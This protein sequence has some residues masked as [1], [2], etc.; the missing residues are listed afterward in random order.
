MSCSWIGTSGQSPTYFRPFHDLISVS[1]DFLSDFNRSEFPSTSG[2]I[3]H[4]H[5][6]RDFNLC[7]PS[8]CQFILLRTLHQF[9]SAPGL[10]QQV[11]GNDF[12]H[13]RLLRL[14]RHFAIRVTV[15]LIRILRSGELPMSEIY[16]ALAARPILLGLHIS[17][18]ALDLRHFP[19]F[20]AFAR[21]PLRFRYGFR[22]SVPG[23][24]LHGEISSASSGV[25]TSAS[26]TFSLMRPFL[27]Q[28]FRHAIRLSFT[29]PPFPFPLELPGFPVPRTSHILPRI[30][31]T[32]SPFLRQLFRHA[33][34]LSF[35]LPPFPFP[36]ELPGFPVPTFVDGKITI[37]FRSRLQDDLSL[38]SG[39]ISALQH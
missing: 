35:T 5:P 2:L 25:I 32:F 7:F 26:L 18:I 6:F 15:E 4:L 27:R 17:G 8:L 20:P 1:S 30:I 23:I 28:L 11:R 13:N 39:F 10:L 34:R 21:C 36:L 19:K 16:F 38:E 9:A 37:H 22:A 24:G 31:R 3:P 14:I 29:L 33:I 12:R